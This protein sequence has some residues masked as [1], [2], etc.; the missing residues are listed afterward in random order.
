MFRSIFEHSVR[1]QL[2]ISRVIPLVVR[3]LLNYLNRRLQMESLGCVVSR[4]VSMRCS[5]ER[6][7]ASR[8]FHVRC[9]LLGIWL[10][11]YWPRFNEP[12]IWTEFEVGEMRRG[13]DQPSSRDEAFSS[14]LVLLYRIS[15]SI[16]DPAKSRL[17]VASLHGT[18]S[19]SGHDNLEKSSY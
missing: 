19:A 16:S 14:L 11:N 10:N 2:S 3:R 12:W 5:S 17:W 13:I 7:V 1:V 15:S 9:G 8:R 18:C 6:R 4:D